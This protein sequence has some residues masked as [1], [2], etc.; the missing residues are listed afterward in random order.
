MADHRLH[1]TLIGKQPHIVLRS[2]MKNTLS[3]ETLKALL[4]YDP[5]TRVFI[6]KARDVWYFSDGAQ[7]A[8]HNQKIWNSKFAGKMTGSR[9]SHGYST[10]RIFDKLYGAHRLAWLYMTGEMPEEV[11]HINLRRDDN[12]WHNLRAATHVQNSRNCARKKN[13][14]V[15]LKGVHVHEPGKWRARIQHHGE[16]ICLG[17]YN[18]PAAAYFAYVVGSEIVHGEFARA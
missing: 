15:G 10:I 14:K 8:S 18:C 11:D 1:C 6:W 3:Q 2:R 7:T 9:N 5:C 13:N 12:A 17:V 16:T 4:H